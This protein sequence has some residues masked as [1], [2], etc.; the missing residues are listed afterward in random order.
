MAKNQRFII[1]I[2]FLHLR[3]IAPIWSCR[4]LTCAH[5]GAYYESMTKN[6]SNRYIALNVQNALE[7]AGYTIAEASRQTG[8]AVTT[9]RRR[10]QKPG[11]FQMNELIALADITKRSPMSFLKEPAKG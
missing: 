3:F 9:L 4:V 2:K 7:K 11:S 6:E 5:L 1:Y 8:I 10:F